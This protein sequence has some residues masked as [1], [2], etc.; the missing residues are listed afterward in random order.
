LNTATE[1]KEERDSEF[2]KSQ[3]K[4]RISQYINTYI[5][6]E[7]TQLQLDNKARTHN[8]IRDNPLVK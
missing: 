7:E 6:I 8:I 2:D 3:G 4:Q 1:L 5:C